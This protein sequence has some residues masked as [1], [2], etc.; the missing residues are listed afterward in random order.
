MNIITNFL[1]RENSTI[2][3]ND[4]HLFTQVILGIMSFQNSYE[5]AYH[6]HNHVAYRTMF[7][8]SL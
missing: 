4:L 1:I 6:N 7:P 2:E 8:C 3:N 5:V